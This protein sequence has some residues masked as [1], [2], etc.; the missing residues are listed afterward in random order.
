MI[1]KINSRDK[2]LTVF[3]DGACRLCNREISFYK[4]QRGSVSVAWVDVTKAAEGDVFPGLSRDKALARFHVVDKS[5]ALFSGGAAFSRMWLALPVF[6]PL[7]VLLQV[8]PFS[9]IFE[10]VYQ[11]F[12]K[13]RPRLQEFF[14][15]R[16]QTVNKKTD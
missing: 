7:G 5:G 4:R 16:D 15:T 3:Y 6:K 8:W 10:W 13:F 11:R 12:L 1:D 14:L 9:L 2:D